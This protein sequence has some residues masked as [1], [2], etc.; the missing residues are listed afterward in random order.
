MSSDP[1]QPSPADPHQP[2]YS[3]KP[4]PPYRF[5][6]GLYPHPRRDARGHSFGQPEPDAAPVAPERWMESDTYCY[7][8]DLFNYAYWWECHEELEALWHEVGHE[9]EQGQFLQGIVQI[10]A[11]C[12]RRFMDDDDD[13]GLS[14]AE[15]GLAKLRTFAGVY[16][17]IDV[18]GFCNDVRAYFSDVRSLPPVIT[19]NSTSPNVGKHW[20]LCAT[21]RHA[22]EI[23]SSRGSTFVRCGLSA[24]DKNFPKYPS[25]P[26]LTCTGYTDRPL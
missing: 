16:M 15:K 14:L 13:A 1:N 21:C 23:H 7:G 8:I 3:D 2:R 25:L 12:L 26:V 22:Q 11:A 19:L 20:G 17:G 6:P 9:S 4:F 10:A 24:A 18:P 5:V